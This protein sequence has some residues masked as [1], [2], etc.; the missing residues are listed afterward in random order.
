[1]K[2]AVKFRALTRSNRCERHE[3][4]KRPLL[5]EWLCEVDPGGEP[6]AA[7]VASRDDLE[8]IHQFEHC[9]DLFELLE[10]IGFVP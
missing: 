10:Q 2:G 4:E 1:M 7:L 6:D 9:R 3:S 8:A 5:A